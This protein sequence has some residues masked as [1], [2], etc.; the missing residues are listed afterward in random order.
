MSC[1]FSPA[2]LLASRFFI[3][4]S[5]GVLGKRGRT[6]AHL[7]TV[8]KKVIQ[9][10]VHSLIY[11]FRQF[12]QRPG[13]L[14][15]CSDGMTTEQE[16]Y[17]GQLAREAGKPNSPFLRQCLCGSQAT[18]RAHPLMEA[19][20]AFVRRLE[21]PVGDP[22]GTSLQLHGLAVRAVVWPMLPMD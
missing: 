2:K 22:M 19:H 6:K 18:D 7:H 14:A 10:L 3:N 1:L 13:V 8:Y 11:K 20:L 12:Q 5:E 16:G 9:H 21:L 17:W 15:S 4:Q